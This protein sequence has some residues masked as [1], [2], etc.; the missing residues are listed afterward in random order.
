M[1][2][3]IINQTVY[4]VQ[5]H[6]NRTLLGVVDS[7]FESAFS[8]P[9]E[10]DELPPVRSNFHGTLE[11]GSTVEPYNFRPYNYDSASEPLLPMFPVAYQFSHRKCPKQD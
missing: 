5:F 2:L 8:L 1:D 4:L 6:E 3:K 11:G 7:I 10:L 9:L